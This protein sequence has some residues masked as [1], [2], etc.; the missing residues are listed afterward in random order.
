MATIAL[1]PIGDVDDRFL[2][3]LYAST[4]LDELALLPEEFVAPFTNSQYEYQRAHYIRNFPAAIWSVIEHL[5][6]P[7]GRIIVDRSADPWRLIDVAVLT[8]WRNHGIGT[9][10][11]E[12]LVAEA[13]SAGAELVLSVRVENLAAR[14]LYERLGFSVRDEI[15]AYMCMSTV[16]ERRAE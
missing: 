13:A 2:R 11:L 7:V 6:R 14:R 16:L 8:E 12:S 5:G 3:E 10:L 15:G 1:R 9:W 4:R